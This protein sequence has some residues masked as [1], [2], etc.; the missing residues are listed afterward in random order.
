MFFVCVRYSVFQSEV[1]PVDEAIKTVVMRDMLKLTFHTGN[2]PT[3][4]EL[5]Q[6]NNSFLPVVTQA[7]EY[8]YKEFMVLE[9]IRHVYEHCCGVRGFKKSGGVGSIAFQRVGRKLH[10]KAAISDLVF[11]KVSVFFF[12]LLS[13]Y[14]YVVFFFF[15]FFR[16]CVCLSNILSLFINI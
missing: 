16:L 10:V 7:N 14:E 9:R 2:L 5:I 3:D 13:I 6:N 1:S 15:F 12:F 8:Q 4:K 11:V